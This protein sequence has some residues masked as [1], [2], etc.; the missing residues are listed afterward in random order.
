[1][2]NQGL[3]IDPKIYLFEPQRGPLTQYA[4]PKIQL[5]LKPSLKLIK[6]SLAQSLNLI[7]Y[8][9]SGLS[10]YCKAPLNIYIALF[11]KIGGR[12]LQKFYSLRKFTLS[13]MLDQIIFIVDNLS[14]L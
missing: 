4:H 3:K 9:I 1:M 11:S 10:G 2:R 14:N 13:K 6:K 5:E 12:C 8:F 7:Q